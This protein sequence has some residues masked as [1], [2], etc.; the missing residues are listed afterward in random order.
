M[1]AA[2][3]L[4]GC[5]LIF[6]ISCAVKVGLFGQ[7]HHILLLHLLESFTHGCV[8]PL[9]IVIRVVIRI[10]F[11]VKNEVYLSIFS[12]FGFSF[13]LPSF[14]LWRRWSPKTK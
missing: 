2:H 12:C 1:T 10:I 5:F 13:R 11:I 7:I 8:A 6:L 3:S 9:G 14:R 4:G